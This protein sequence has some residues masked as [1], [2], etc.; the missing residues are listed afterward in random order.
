[1]SPLERRLGA[2]WQLA[3][4]ELGLTVTV[5]AQVAVAGEPGTPGVALTVPVLVHGYGRPSGTAVVVVGQPSELSAGLLRQSR[6]NLYVATVAPHLVNYDRE[7][8]I[9][10]LCD[11]GCYGQGIAR[12]AWYQPRSRPR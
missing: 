12:P 1:M 11:W 3:A 7:A 8:Y 4:A 6:D 2:A 9:A 10:L 5:A